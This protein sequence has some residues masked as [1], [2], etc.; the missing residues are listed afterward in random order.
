MTKTKTNWSQ[1][2]KNLIKRG[3][4][5]LWIAKDIEKWWYAKAVPEKGRPQVYSE[6]AIEMC[7]ML[8]HIYQLPLRMAEG[9]INSLFARLNIPLKCPSYT[10]LSRRAG[11]FEVPKLAIKPGIPVNL[12][13]DSTGLKV[14][15]EG[16][17]KVRMHGKSKRRTW[18]KL[19]AAVNPDTLEFIATVLTSN[20]VTDSAA[21]TQI[22]SSELDGKINTVS[23][24]GAYDKSEFYKQACSI[25]ALTVVPPASNARMQ[26]LLHPAMISRDESIA[27]IKLYGNDEA[28]RKRWKE[29]VGYHSRSLAETAMFR[30]KTAFSDRLQSRSFAA[31]STEVFLK[32]N[33]L[34]TYASMGFLRSF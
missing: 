30:F 16:E 32:T 23:G 31:Q 6:K 29:E 33:I 9:F 2:N 26:K 5:D 27:K 18:M 15:G 13:F 3:N 21:A 10:Q 28:A 8:R 19:H 34:N 7:L 17:W 11:T 22:M 25:G 4:I 24:D 1:Y 20:A 14:F 12:I